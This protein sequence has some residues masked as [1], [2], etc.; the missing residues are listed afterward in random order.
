MSEPASLTPGSSVP[1]LRLSSSR[2]EAS[3]TASVER[4]KLV[5]DGPAVCVPLFVARSVIVNELDDVAT[6]R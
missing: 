5:V 2:S 6:E 3:R 1:M 4:K